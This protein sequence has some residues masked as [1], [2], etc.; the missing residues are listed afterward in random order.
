MLRQSRVRDLVAYPTDRTPAGS[1]PLA[2]H[3]SSNAN[4]ATPYDLITQYT[5]HIGQGDRR[6][7]VTLNGRVRGAGQKQLSLPPFCDELLRTSS[8]D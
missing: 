6:A 3:P 5:L 1:T 7:L 4:P 8:I 2:R